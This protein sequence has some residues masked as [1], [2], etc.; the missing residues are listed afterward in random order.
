MNKKVIDF[1]LPNLDRSNIKHK[2]HIMRMI[3][4][5]AD[6]MDTTIDMTDEFWIQ[7][8][9]ND[10]EKFEAC[11][12]Y[13]ALV[14][15]LAQYRKELKDCEAGSDEWEGTA[16]EIERCYWEINELSVQHGLETVD[17]PELKMLL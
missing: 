4:K 16:D 12:E 17:R 11:V 14:K 10:R 1:D 5:N 2:H 13:D 15:E 7:M 8:L 3:K 6:S 9:K